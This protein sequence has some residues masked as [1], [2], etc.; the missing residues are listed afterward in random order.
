MSQEAEL[1]IN[2]SSIER[3]TVAVDSLLKS[4]EDLVK[5]SGQAEGANENLTKSERSKANAVL[6]ANIASEKAIALLKL[7]QRGLDKTS[8]EYVELKA[9]IIAKEVAAKKGIKTSSKEYKSLKDNIT[10]KEKAIAATKSLSL[11]QKRNNAVTNDSSKSFTGFTNR[12]DDATKQVRLIDGPLGGVASRMTAF[13][14]IVKSGATGLAIFGVATGLAFREIYKGVGIAADTEVALA[15]F[16]A[17]IRATGGAAGFTAGELDELSRSL[18]LNTLDS[19]ADMRKLV[20]VMLTFKSV[21]GDS[22]TRAIGLSQDLGKA[23]QQDP[24]T[25]AR[26]LGKVL[27]NP[28]KNYKQLSRA[29]IQFGIEEAKNIKKLQQRGEIDQ[30]QSII[31]D[32]L[33]DKFGGLAVAQAD[34]L[35]G[36]IDT[37]NQKWEETSEIIGKKLLPSMR[38]LT[39]FGGDAVEALGDFLESDVEGIVSDWAD[40]FERSKKGL[41]ELTPELERVQKEIADIG[42]T[43]GIENFVHF[44]GEMSKLDS[45]L[46]ATAV[47]EVTALKEQERLLLES[48]KARNDALS[49]PVKN[50]ELKKYKEDGELA[51]STEQKLTA[52][53]LISGNTRSESYRTEKANVDALRLAKKL[54]IEG[55]EVE[56]KAIA[57]HIKALSDLTEKRVLHNSE[58]QR[59]K[60]IL[61]KQGGLEKEI[62][63][64]KLLAT[65]V[66]ESSSEYLGLAATYDAMNAAEL[67]GIAIGSETY[68]AMKKRK[69]S[70]VSL[71]VELKKLNALEASSEAHEKSK[72]SLEDQ[73]ELQGLTKKGVRETSK[74]YFRAEAA[75]SARNEAIE[76]GFAV[77]SD[78]YLLLKKQALALADLRTEA[79]K[80]ADLSDGG[81]SVS[82]FGEILVTGSKAALAAADTEVSGKLIN[83]LLSGTIDE[84]AFTEKM[85]EVQEAIRERLKDQLAPLGFTID[86]EGKEVLLES[87][88]A[89]EVERQEKLKE[90]RDAWEEQTITDETLYRERLAA[91]ETEYDEK[92]IASKQSAYEKTAKHKKLMMQKEVSNT[93]A[94]GL[95]NL[96]AV[97]GNNKKL[98]KAAK[99]MSMFSAST[100]LVDALSNASSLPYPANIPAYAQAFLQGTQ[101]ISMA[102]S[103][104]EPA[105]ANGGVDIKG[106]GTGRSDNISAKIANGES[107]ITATGTSRHKETLKRIN[108]GL[109]ISGGRGNGGAMS[110]STSIVVQGDASE[111]TISLIEDK[112]RDFE[113]RVETIANGSAMQTI[114]EQQMV[115][116]LFNEI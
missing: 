47:D 81:F 114:Q 85:N 35:K 54:G 6:N 43:S 11:S 29:G 87:V 53:F 41:V 97:T 116:G 42:E 4:L 1:K 89:V 17:Q 61:G 70:L 32:K 57:D 52:A 26:T 15:S 67:A 102:S 86:E 93:I 16:D 76:A 90:L 62:A 84:A 48:I 73:I 37:F 66:H 28:L 14:Q 49:A 82:Q 71:Q 113:T 94:N 7:E 56:I 65:G 2:S 60:S 78:E 104:N 51:L 20:G 5:T 40:G 108:A 31:L 23:M 19:T 105:F 99:L 112:L 80:V 110:L 3:T 69:T 111:N 68:N 59:E 107:V 13:S 95:E 9:A 39:K 12:L 75:I 36:D 33:K 91:V 18:A 50:D 30:A 45:I 100:S 21:S 101:L 98:A 10:A 24:V 44:V 88:E 72:R 74:E 25:A 109:D 64:R 38:Q 115:G 58:V 63:L 106:A 27:E 8:Q 77:G 96:A 79:Q 22:L 83:L 34:T 46:P 92:S 103:L 55:D